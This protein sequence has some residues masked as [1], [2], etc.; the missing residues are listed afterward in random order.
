MYIRYIQLETILTLDNGFHD[1]DE[2]V[3]PRHLSWAIQQKSLSCGI[4]VSFFSARGL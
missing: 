1:Y 3:V 4:S 2:I